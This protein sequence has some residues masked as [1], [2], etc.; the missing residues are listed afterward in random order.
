MKYGMTILLFA[1]VI[2]LRCS[3]PMA[4]C[5]PRVRRGHRRSFVSLSQLSS[6][7]RSFARFCWILCA[8]RTLLLLLALP[9]SPSSLCPSP[10]AMPPR[11][12]APSAAAGSAGDLPQ[13]LETKVVILGHT[14]EKQHRVT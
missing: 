12:A 11:G 9:S 2:S 8:A 1:A 13:T 10:A 5:G 3:N 14:G 7:T 4:P 6:L